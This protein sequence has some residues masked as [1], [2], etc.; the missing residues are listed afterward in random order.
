MIKIAIADDHELIRKGLSIFINTREDMQVHLEATS[1]HELVNDLSKTTIDL[2]ILDLNLGDMNGLH[3]IEEINTRYPSL[4]ILVLSAYP[5]NVYALR[6]FK[7]GASGYLNKS[8]VSEALIDAIL[9]VTKGK[10]YI[11]RTFEEILPLGT[12][13]EKEEKDLG[14]ILSKREF[15]VLNL[16]AAGNTP[17]E[18]AQSMQL[19][20]KTISTYQTRIIE[21]LSLESTMQLQRFA[22]ETF[23]STSPNTML[24]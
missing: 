7:S 12:E 20:P 3:T 2:L 19:S 15:E 17:K 22:Y 13:P 5:E 4:P 1:F 14:E 21:K 24:P 23:F 16:I 11:S 10:K 8:A 9:T 18:I 6:A